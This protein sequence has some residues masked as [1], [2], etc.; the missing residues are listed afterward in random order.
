MMKR[1]FI[2]A[3]GL[4]GA[5]ALVRTQS[6][7]LT[8]A[9][10]EWPAVSGDLG[11]TRYTTLT[12]INRDTLPKLKGAWQ[13]ERFVDG[14]AGRAMP[15]V[16]DGMVFLTGGSFV[17]AFDAKT[18][19]TIWKHQTGAAAAGNNSGLNEFAQ[20]E[21]GLPDREGVAV[22]DG[23]VFVGLSNAHAIA[24]DEKTGNQ[25]WDSYAGIDPPRPGQAL[26]GA[27]V[28][29]GGLVFVGTS[30]DPGFRG[31]VVAFDAN[32]GKK[33]WEFFVVPGP[34]DAG[35]ETWPPTDTYKVGGGAIWLVG[36]A[37][38][39]LGL[40]YFGTGNGVPQYG[41]DER[42]GTNLYLCSIIALDIKTGK[43]KWHF[44]T[45]RHDIWEADIAMSPILVNTQI[46]GR[47]RKLI[48]AMR[49]DGTLF[50]VD[51]ETGKP[52]LP[53]EDRKVPQDKTQRTW[54]T[55]PYPVGADHML[56]ERDVWAKKPIQI[57]R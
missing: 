43:L 38:P 35:H 37:D 34:E 44:Q 10:K 29:A 5:T 27:R 50:V 56:D 49:A 14:G 6:N 26:P 22:A 46:A 42:A 9:G 53:I 23:K 33:A 39:E 54:P 11:N 47:D 25:L 48:A 7:A 31:K 30:A 12:Q 2:V 57:G 18:G 52:V 41:G 36:A 20:R 28:V 19:A 13:T 15:V 17:Y 45:I 51:R 3:L 55:Q 16:K 32:T 1:L 4:A 24:L 21:P 8:P 40:V